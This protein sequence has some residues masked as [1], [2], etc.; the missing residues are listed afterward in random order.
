MSMYAP[1]P[2]DLLIAEWERSLRAENKSPRTIEGYTMWADRFHA[3]TAARP[4]PP[5]DAAEV[6]K[7]HVRAWIA[8]R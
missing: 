2:F 5:A 7:T 1:P 4:D 6:T 8:H 3:W